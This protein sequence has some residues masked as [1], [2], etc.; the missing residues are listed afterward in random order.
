[1]SVTAAL[2][3]AVLVSVIVSLPPKRLT[4][5]SLASDGTV[6]GIIHVHSNRSDGRDS[7][8]DIA[9]AAARAGL[10]FVVFTDH[11]D[12]TRAPDPPV[13]RSGVLCFDAVEIS[14]TEGHYL[15]LDMPVAPYPLNGEARDVVEDVQRLGGFGVVAHPES[16]KPALAWQAWDAPY[17][18]I[19]WVNP[20][21]SWRV[22]L[23]GGWDSHLS[24]AT[25]LVSY[26]F[27]PAEAIA[28]LLGGTT[29]HAERWNALARSR[30][31]VLLAGADAHARLEIGNTDPQGNG[32]SLP[33]PGYEATFRALSVRVTPDA[34]LSGDAA[35]DGA[36]L[37]RSLRHGHAHVVIDGLATA[38]SFRFTADTSAGTA[39]EGDTLPR[40]GP[41]TLH[42]ES[43]A[44][45]SFTTVIWQDD[46]VLASSQGEPDLRRVVTASGVY[47]VEISAPRNGGAVPWIVSNPIYVGVQFPEPVPKAAP[48]V[49]ESRPLLLEGSVAGWWTES[50]PRSKTSI[51]SAPREGS[52]LGFRYELASG[53]SSGQ[54]AALVASIPKG[55]RYRRLAFSARSG[56]PMRISVQLRG[57]EAL[58]RWQRAVYLDENDRSYAIEFSDLT[59]V[60]F[61]PGHR[62][63]QRDLH[64]VLIVVDTMHARP[65]SSGQIWLKT[66]ALEQ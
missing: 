9:Q 34:A 31:L 16:P 27:R 10:K 32:R 36:A 30:R 19:E 59:P 2:V 45:P 25:A 3:A 65:G 13:Y 38:P 49:V 41:V 56:R 1:M 47:R 46:S 18:G 39:Y 23:R 7:V 42:V 54:Y 44:P 35:S 40:N 17:D 28:S 15:A 62:P 6:P 66:F 53:S 61:A 37:M 26:P 57:A 48:A 58:G 4:L 8:D 21:T 50:D 60:G 63:E 33:I 14:T 20:D 29:L 55:S 43:N 24:L 5:T 22:R 11:G 64:D 12:G 51:V 52:T